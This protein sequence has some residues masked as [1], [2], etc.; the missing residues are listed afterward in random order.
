MPQRSR[1][2][3]ILS[4]PCLVRVYSSTGGASCSPVSSCCKASRLRPSAT[5]CTRWV[6]AK[7]SSTC[8]GVVAGNDS[9]AAATTDDGGTVSV[10]TGAVSQA[11]TA[12][13]SA[14]SAI[15]VDC[16]DC[17]IVPVSAIAT[18]ATATGVGAAATS[19]V[20]F[21]VVSVLAMVVSN[22]ASGDA[23]SSASWVAA[24]TF[25][26][27]VR[28]RRGRLAG[29]S[30]GSVSVG[31]CSAE[32]SESGDEDAGASPSLSECMQPVTP[33]KSPRRATRRAA[34]VRH[35]E[36]RLAGLQ[37]CCRT[38]EPRTANGASA[39]S[40]PR[41]AERRRACTRATALR[42]NS[43]LP[44]SVDWCTAWTART[45]REPAGKVTLA[46]TPVHR[47]TIRRRDAENAEEGRHGAAWSRGLPTPWI[48]V[49][50][51]TNAIS[52]TVPHALWE[53]LRV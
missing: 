43:P 27:R 34:E 41:I 38:S 50:Q 3:A 6:I 10:A 45:V 17:V 13:G 22:F 29:G 11:A 19:E 26:L 37:A 2:R 42:T 15:G 1:K 49:S 8:V 44:G 48:S 16:S 36:S 4:A 47:R 46:Q 9:D 39:T 24:G 28:V 51:A 53:F 7:G 32:W 23:T 14:A 35:G 25:G 21:V 31:G 52:R 18:D 5:G 20:A 33:W 40:D 12:M 30:A